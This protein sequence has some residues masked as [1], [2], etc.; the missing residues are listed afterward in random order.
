MLTGGVTGADWGL[1]QSTELKQLVAK[2]FLG[3][4]WPTIAAA[5][6]AGAAAV[7][8]AVLNTLTL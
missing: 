5:A 4:S 1:K 8:A 2:D 6:A 7:A 3:S